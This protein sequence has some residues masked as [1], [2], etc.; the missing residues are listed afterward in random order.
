M[1]QL[2]EAEPRR[3]AG[4]ADA[5]VV[6]TGDAVFAFEF[7][8]SEA[9]TAEDALKPIGE[10]GVLT[11]YAASGKKAVKVGAEFSAKERALSRWVVG[12]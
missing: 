4:R 11:P 9:A 3:A 2:V 5:V 10:K 8:L 7:K 12:A 6:V 1:G